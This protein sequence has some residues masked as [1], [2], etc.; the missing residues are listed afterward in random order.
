MNRLEELIE[1][2]CPDGVEYKKTSDLCIDKFW[3]MPATPKYIECGIPYITSKNIRDNHIDFEN[4]SYISENDYVAMSKNRAINKGDLLITMIGTI[5]EAAFVE[6]DTAFYGQNMYLLRLNTNAIVPMYFY[7]YLTSPKIKEGLISKK[8][9]SSQ[10]YIKAGS[11][12]NLAIPVPPLEV[13]SEIVRILD[14]FTKLTAE[15]TA[16]K[17]Q[18]EYYLDKLLTFKEKV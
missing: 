4:V 13:Q 5:G 15:L 14:N 12:D 16:R 9:P 17:K 6:T 1:K 2:L 18:Y 8:N 7:Y 3:L 11:I 10:G